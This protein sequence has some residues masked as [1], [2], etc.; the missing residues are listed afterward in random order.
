[1][2]ESDRGA[3]A[4]QRGAGLA[5][6]SARDEGGA[7]GTI[8]GLSLALKVRAAFEAA[9]ALD[10]GN[11]DAVNDLGEYYIAAP[12]V[13]GGGL[14][15]SA[16]LANQALARRPQPAHRILAMT[17]EKRRTMARPSVSFGQPL[18]WP[19]AGCVE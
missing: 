10:P 8:S 3:S 5:G 9:V 2:R 7:G 1:M 16:A 18:R 13:I 17:A 15:K 12:M 4:Q 11:G 6:E 14:D 19:T